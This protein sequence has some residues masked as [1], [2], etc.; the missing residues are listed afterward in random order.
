[1]SSEPAAGVTDAVIL[2]AGNGDRFQDPNHRSKLLHP[3]LGKPLILRT[4]ESAAAAG[5]MSL[6][7]V[8][9][10]DAERVRRVIE[11]QP[12]AGTSV[13]F[14]HNPRWQLENGV[15]ALSAEAICVAERFALLMGDHLFDPP[16][17]RRLCRY[18]VAPGE[19][20]LAVDARASDPVTV[21]EA[22]RVR[23]DGDRIIAIGKGLTPWDALDTGLFVFTPALF[24]ALRDAQEA[25]DTTL[26][27]GVQRLAHW[28]VMRGAAV[29]DSTWCDIDTRDDLGSAEALFAPAGAAR[30]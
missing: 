4:L 16:V 27:A 12:I 2:A 6:H 3:F 24:S 8:V 5:L 25:G 29:V 1:M 28:R 22:T 26:S 11:S 30:A 21:D 10:F 23:L 9:G 17:L 18:P 19:S 14:I 7:V 20:V 13:D 15:S